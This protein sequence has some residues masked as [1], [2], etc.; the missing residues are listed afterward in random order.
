MTY[1]ALA[2]G[3]D[4]E[5]TAL[6]NRARTSPRRAFVGGVVVGGVIGACVALALGTAFGP[7]RVGADGGVGMALARGRAVDAIGDASVGALGALHFPTVTCPASAVTFSTNLH[8]VYG[9]SVSVQ[10]P[11]ECGCTPRVMGHRECICVG[12]NTVSVGLPNAHI[13]LQLE[14]PSMGGVSFCDIVDTVKQLPEIADNLVTKL[15]SLV[16]L[17]WD[18]WLKINE[19]TL[20]EM[21]QKTFADA[22]D[23][24]S[25]T[26][27]LGGAR[28]AQS[29]DRAE[30]LTHLR[31]NVKR[32]F[33]GKD[34]VESSSISG[35]RGNST[36]PDVGS[37]G[38]GS[39]YCYN[40]PLQVF[41]DY[42]SPSPDMP[43]P[44]KF[45]ND[46]FA[47]NAFRMKFPALHVGLCQTL[48]EFDV[49]HEVAVRL[50]QSFLKMYHAMFVAIYEASGV[51]GVVESIKD[52]GQQIVGRKLLGEEANSVRERQA[53]LHKQLKETETIFYKE[54]VVLHEI[55][56]TG[57]A[58]FKPSV[59]SQLG[60]ASA[61]ARGKAALGGNT[62]EDVFEDFRADL[63]S[64]LSEMKHMKIR[65]TSTL[66]FGASFGVELSHVLFR[67]G[68]I[69]SEF[70]EKEETISK[71]LVY[72]IGP[73][74][75]AVVSVELDVR[76][77][78]YFRAEV[79]GSFEFE[80]SVALPVTLSLG[81]SASAT[82]VRVGAPQISIDSPLAGY[83]VAG[84][85]IGA[86]AEIVSAYVALCAGP[87]CAGPDIQARQDVYVGF[88]I[89]AQMQE[90][91]AMCYAGPESLTAMW[92]DWDYSD[93]TKNQCRRSQLG[94]GAYLQIPKTILAAQVVLKPLPTI[95][96]PAGM[97]PVVTLIDLEPFISAA[98]DSRGNYLAQELFHACTLPQNEPIDS[99]NPVCQFTKSVP[100]PIPAGIDALKRQMQAAGAVMNSDRKVPM[101]TVE[102]RTVTLQLTDGFVDTGISDLESGS[103][104]IEMYSV[105]T[106]SVGGSLW[107]E[108]YTGLMTWYNRGTNSHA[109][110]HILLHA[111]G[112]A[113]YGKIL[114]QTLENSHGSLS[115]QV[116]L[117]SGHTP[118]NPQSYT[119]KFRRVLPDPLSVPPIGGVAPRNVM[120]DLSFFPV[121]LTTSPGEWIDTG[122]HGDDLSLGSY[123]VQIANVNTYSNGGNQY[124]ETYTGVMSWFSGGTNSYES[125]EIALHA[126]GH[127]INGAYVK[128]RTQRSPRQ[129]NTGKNLRL[130]LSTNDGL[131][132]PQT[133]HIWFRRI[134]PAQTGTAMPIPPGIPVDTIYFFT[135]TFV[136]SEVWTPVGIDH[137]ALALGSYAVQ[138]LPV[139]SMR[140]GGVMYSEL[141]SGVMTW[142]NRGTNDNSSDEIVLHQAGHAPNNDRLQ[143]RTRRRGQSTLQ[144]EIRSQFS[145]SRIGEYCFAFRRLV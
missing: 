35:M 79:E 43:W 52:M 54:L 93:A 122:I 20:L 40:I 29:A 97:E 134:F 140:Y 70:F 132:D 84:M 3:H 95:E 129:Q 46:A 133:Y 110:S 105:N 28:G 69:L 77:P 114:L 115:L 86:V 2:G 125:N 139:Q 17:I 4:D 83:A 68:E 78:Y 143:L 57:A 48:H 63:I 59:T 113:S 30:F 98:H 60:V 106:A 11:K 58:G 99:C 72:P 131:V 62:F 75:F 141:A 44:E 66:E 88:D 85:Q 56:N 121:T 111:A 137:T 118:R 36:Y 15:E 65:A 117:S 119:F 81:G 116:R 136:L 55:F 90:G 27:A 76:L 51:K 101:D 9:D 91:D 6:V 53:E 34:L 82:Y 38:T 64:A 92:T 135:K 120:D 41:S 7:A 25:A 26:A 1:G 49:P 50:I 103:Y 89:F 12:G 21:I 5:T 127:A 24:F 123:F 130:Q 10:L 8:S 23:G 126:A 19:N 22:T 87:V 112:H 124:Q 67:E 108:T 33:E 128:L 109:A 144:L 94:T 18:P 31:D 73:G 100:H 74:L 45:A 107:S 142:Y 104:L 37:L 14:L 39:G 102:V 61:K 96:L 16:G 47:P 32:A 71:E 80:V 138:I 13:D 145:T 42:E